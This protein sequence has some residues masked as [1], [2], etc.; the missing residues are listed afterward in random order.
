[1][2][3]TRTLLLTLLINLLAIIAFAQ[4]NFQL[5]PVAQVEHPKLDEQFTQYQTLRLDQQAWYTYFLANEGPLHFTLQLGQESPLHLQLAPYELR[6]AHFQRFTET[7]RGVVSSP[8][9]R[10]SVYRGVVAAADQSQGEAIFTFDEQFVLGRWDDHGTTY[11][12]KP[13]WRFVPEAD[14]ATYVVYRAE[15]AII[16]DNFCGANVPAQMKEMDKPQAGIAKV[17]ECLLTE[18]ALAS[19]FELYQDFNN[20]ATSVENFMLN[21]LANV[22]TNYDNEFADEILF[23]VVTTFIA[24]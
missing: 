7:D 13:L 10:T 6:A 16:P 11:F 20:N 3:T 2:I 23:D 17:G 4:N 5:A 8:A 9:T 18:L 12:L 22:Q 21:N 19:D 24:T 14:P 1:M 15:D